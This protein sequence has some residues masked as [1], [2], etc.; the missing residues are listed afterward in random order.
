MNHPLQSTVFKKENNLLVKAAETYGTPTYCYSKKRLEENTQRLNKAIKNYFP[1]NKIYY[2]V[3]ANSNIHIIKL[4]KNSLKELGCDCSSPG[5]LF[6][7]NKAGVDAKDC[8]Y[9]GNY[10]SKEDLKIAI[11][12]NCEINLDDLS[13]FKRLKKIKI[14]EYISFRLNPGEGHGEF[15]GIVT[16][17][18][19]SKFGIPSEKI[20][21]AYLFAKNSGVKYFGLQCH[22]G[23]STIEVSAFTNIVKL[24]LKSAKE[25]ESIINQRLDKISIGSGFG[26]PYRDHEKPLDLDSLFK[27]IQK[28]FFEYYN[29]DESTWPTLC[30]EPGRIIVGDT[31]I[32]I[33]KV[34]GIKKSYKNFVGLDAG[35]ETLMRPALYGA[36]HRLI[37]I[38]PDEQYNDIELSGFYDVTGRIC[39]NTDRIG[40]RVALPKINENDLIAIMDVGAYGYSMSH[41]FNTR[42]RPPE[43][44]LNENKITLIRKRETISDIFSGCDV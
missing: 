5:E 13:S 14:P 40:E 34:T 41:Q 20:G 25:I 43:V 42:P 17:G 15:S 37:K 24:I 44:I 11:D 30:I 10:E 23:S 16:G 35:M 1:K 4:L 26:I 27:N 29:A 6:A 2:A 38:D 31:G 7:A 8:V 28:L 21:K 22:A 19:N 3:K 39:E 18:K 36:H 12:S 32:I 33:S 9:T